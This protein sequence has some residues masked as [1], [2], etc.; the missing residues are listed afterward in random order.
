MA[1][2]RI[3]CWTLILA[4]YV[5]LSAVLLLL[6]ALYRGFPIDHFLA[7]R[8]LVLWTGCALMVLYVFWA[9]F[10]KRL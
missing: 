4:A 6:G 9:M 1:E 2:R 8:N 10:V 7:A 3:G 5:V